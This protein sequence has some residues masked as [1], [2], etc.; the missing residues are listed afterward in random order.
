MGKLNLLH[1]KTWHVYSKANRDRVR[2]DEEVYEAEQRKA[3]EKIVKA[4]QEARLAQLRRGKEATRPDESLHDQTRHVN[5]F[6]EEEQQQGIVLLKSEKELK[7]KQW[8]DKHTMYLGETKDGKKE[9]AWYN[10]LDYGK[11]DR[12]ARLD[13]EKRKRREKRDESSKRR[14]DPLKLMKD[15]L[16]SKETGSSQFSK[17]ADFSGASKVSKKPSAS[18]TIEELRQDRLAR[19]MKERTRTQALLDPKAALENKHD[20]R[21][22]YYNSQFNREHTR[23]NQGRSL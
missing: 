10:S 9:S 3:E 19:E 4:D 18:K 6:Q 22:G 15:Y 12:E 7:E 11:R 20:Q 2:K 1:H 21:K 23:N 8:Q 16:A 17:Y 13:P 14:D 5:L